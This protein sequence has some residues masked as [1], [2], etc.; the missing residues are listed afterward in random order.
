[1]TVTSPVGRFVYSPSRFFV[2]LLLATLLSMLLQIGSIAAAELDFET[3]SRL[4]PEVRIA[5]AKSPLAKRY[6]LRGISSHFICTAFSTAPAG[7]TLP[8][9]QNS[10]DGK[11][12]HR[13]LLRQSESASDR[14]CRP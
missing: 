8:S 14:R 5:F 6:P 10:L 1:M 9:D 4:P 13:D 12:R 7:K 2:L 3:L 11:K